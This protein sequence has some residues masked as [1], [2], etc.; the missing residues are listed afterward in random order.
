MTKVYFV[1]H[2]QPEDES[3]LMLKQYMYLEAEVSLIGTFVLVMVVKEIIVGMTC[4]L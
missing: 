2:A 4:I 3:S 1:R